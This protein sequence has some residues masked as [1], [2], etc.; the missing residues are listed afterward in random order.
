MEESGDG[1]EE[2]RD[3]VMSP[4]PKGLFSGFTSEPCVSKSIDDALIGGEGILGVDHEEVENSMLDS[5]RKVQGTS[6]NGLNSS[7]I[8]MGDSA[9]I[10]TGGSIAERRAATFGFNAAKI[11]NP[12]FRSSSMLPSPGVRSPYLTIPPGISPTALLNSPIMA[13]NPQPSPTTGSFASPPMDRGNEMLISASH[14]EMDKFRDDGLSSMFK[15]RVDPIPMDCGLA[16]ENQVCSTSGLAQSLVAYLQHQSLTSMNLPTDI[17]FPTEIPTE[18]TV[19]NDLAGLPPGRKI[20]NNLTINDKSNTFQSGHLDAVVCVQMQEMNKHPVAEDSG[21]HNSLDGDQKAPTSTLR[22]AEDEYTWRKYG[23]KQVKGSEYPRS[24]YKCTHQNCEVKKKVEHSHDGQIIEIIYKG[25]HNHP[26][27]QPSRKSTSS[28]SETSDAND[29]KGS[30]IKV[31]GGLVW[32]SI[33]SGSRHTKMASDWRA[34]GLERTSSTSVVT[35]VSDLLSTTQGKLMGMHESAGTPEFLSTLAIHED[36]ESEAAAPQGR[37]S[38]EDDGDNEPDSKRRRKEAC[39]IETTLGSTAVR[40]PR[41]V[42][43]IESD[44]D[45]L[46]DGYRWRKYGQKVVKGNPNPRSYY[47]CTNAG[48]TVRKHVERASDNLKCVITTYEGKHNHAVPAAR[49]SSHA[50]SGS[51]SLPPP[52]T[53]AQSA[54][55]LPRQPHLPKAEPHVHELPL[56]FEEK[57]ECSNDFLRPNFLGSLGGGTTPFYQMKFPIFCSATPSGPFGL[58]NHHP[59]YSGGIVPLI[60]EVPIP[61]PVGLAQS[62]S[63]SITNYNNCG[64]SLSSVQPLHTAH[65]LEENNV[66]LLRPKVEHRDDLI[67]D[68]GM[69]NTD[70]A[71]PSSSSIYNHIARS[72]P[73]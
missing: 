47:K 12:R 28:F 58:S 24:Y 40:E 41:V 19:D 9:G 70:H 56:H 20:S 49:N 2:W 32:R 6:E 23:Q 46:D 26:K 13:S 36:D 45:I 16:A 50:N 55:T 37:F 34:D 15:P 54:L 38:F 72:F 31:D 30:S 4:N 21:A 68:T 53:N 48:C 43:Q 3:L 14:A 29:A 51:R 27:P 22:T 66:K 25:T 44:V 62:P 42:V 64:R 17:K 52:G 33:E 63:L 8:G 39:F 71:N 11:S 65:Q 69:E 73:L 61:L 57:K 1:L 67:Y 35:E 60:P 18:V 10:K 59:A 5:K 7:S